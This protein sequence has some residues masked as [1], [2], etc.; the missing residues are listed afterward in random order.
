M[1]QRSWIILILT[2][3]LILAAMYSAIAAG[4]LTVAE[5]T[6]IVLPKD[7]Y[8]EGLVYARLEN[9]GDQ[10]A[11]LAGGLIELLNNR[12]EPIGSLSLEYFDSNPEVMLPGESGFVSA[13]ISAEKALLPDDIANYSLSILSTGDVNRD[14][15]RFSATA[16]YIRIDDVTKA[17]HYI[18]ALIRNDTKDTVFDFYVAYLLRDAQGKLLYTNVMTYNFSGLLP[19]AETLVRAEV[20]EN[21]AAWLDMQGIVPASAEAI[22][23]TSVSR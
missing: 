1:K 16:D 3:A 6:F 19:Q 14:V 4:E 17:H 15:A 9:I 18:R 22:A 23:F 2:P 8:Y 7:S 21:V 12:G 20:K 10:P 11:Q 5:E 13:A